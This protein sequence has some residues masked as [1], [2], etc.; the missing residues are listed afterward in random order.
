[1]TR[2]AHRSDTIDYLDLDDALAIVGD[3]GFH[4]R[5]RGLLGSALARPQASAF[6]EDAYPDLMTK[7]AALFESLVGNHA[8]IDGNKRVSVL[9]T[10]TFLEMNGVRLVHTED[11]AFDF[12]I[13][14]AAGERTLEQIR[15]WFEAHAVP[16]P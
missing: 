12:T 5:D 11:D 1:M 7:T 2:D 4:V 16:T 6:G 8:L 13:E 14:T 9:L 15:D 10:W 3:L